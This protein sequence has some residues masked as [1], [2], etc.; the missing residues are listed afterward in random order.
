MTAANLLVAD[1]ILDSLN[2]GLYVCNTDR[3]IDY[4]S[5][6][7]ERLTGWASADVVG[8]RCM[9]NILNHVDMNGRPLCGEELCPLRRS[10]ITDRPSD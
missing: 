2:D 9:D 6:S 8:H 7:A 4:W 1:V 5:K 3:Q 10:M